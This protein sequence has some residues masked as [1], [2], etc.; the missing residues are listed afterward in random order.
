MR[1]LCFFLAIAAF[2][3][4]VV[5]QHSSAQEPATVPSSGASIM[6]AATWREAAMLT[7][8][9]DIRF[10]FHEVERLRVRGKAKGCDALQPIPLGASYPSLGDW[11]SYCVARVQHDATRC[12]AIAGTLSPDLHRL[13]FSEFRS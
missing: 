1:S 7:S 8:D 11:T 5:T 13:C 2:I 12:E 4:I 6:Q 3:T 9:P 10:L